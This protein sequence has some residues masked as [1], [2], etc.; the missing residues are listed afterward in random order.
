VA[1]YGIWQWT[2]TCYANRFDGWCGVG[3]RC[4]F[5]MFV[6]IVVVLQVIHLC[7][8]TSYHPRDMLTKL[9]RFK[10][11]SSVKQLNCFRG[12]LEKPAE[13]RRIEMAHT[14]S[15]LSRVIMSALC[16]TFSARHVDRPHCLWKQLSNK[17]SK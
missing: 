14:V 10:V 1:S 12:L 3:E 7:L 2:W 4:V 13:Y 17:R 6:W 5:V 15:S 8:Q 11:A 9:G 16:S